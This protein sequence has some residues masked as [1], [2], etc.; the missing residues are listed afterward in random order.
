MCEANQEMDHAKAARQGRLR[1]RHCAGAARG[2]IT[3][4]RLVA[5]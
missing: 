4:A 1:R 5:Q 2:H 3:P